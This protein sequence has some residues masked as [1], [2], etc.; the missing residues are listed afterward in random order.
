MPA[1]IIAPLHSDFRLKAR[2]LVRICA[3]D[4][5]EILP[6]CGV[7]VCS[8]QAKLFRQSRTLRE[9]ERRA[10]SLRDRGYSFLAD[11]LLNVGPQAGELGKHVTNAGPGESWHQYAMALDCVPVKYG[12][13]LWGSNELGWKV[14]GSAANHLGL[15][16]AG[17]W[18][19][20]KELPH[21]QLYPASTPMKQWPRSP[22][23]I[24]Q[25]LQ[26]VHTLA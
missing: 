13:A 3:L 19:G 5:V 6:Y 9:I 16:W 12:K 4:G 20:F 10:Q 25:I 14:Y 2:E 23:I 22:Q 18:T 11:I 1:D 24:G 26:D 17:D 8:A 7:R 21:I 15:T